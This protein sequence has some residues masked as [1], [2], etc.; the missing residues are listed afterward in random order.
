MTTLSHNLSDVFFLPGDGDGDGEG[1]GDGEG[2]DEG[3]GHSEVTTRG[4]AQRN[5]ST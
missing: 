5:T 3:G 1:E 2:D 4:R